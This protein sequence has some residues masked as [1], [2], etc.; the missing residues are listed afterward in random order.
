MKLAG[1]GRALTCGYDIASRFEAL[2]SSRVLRICNS[3]H[4]EVWRASNEMMR[5]LRRACGTFQ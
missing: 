5:S 3:R 1:S 4:N 2:T